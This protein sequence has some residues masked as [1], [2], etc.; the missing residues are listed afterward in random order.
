MNR[1][2]HSSGFTIIEVLCALALTSLLMAALY[3]AMSVYWTT[4]VE[5]YDEIERTQIA[6][7]LLRQM[8]RD[9][10]SCTFVEKETTELESSEDS[11]SDDLDPVDPESAMASYTDGLLGS[12]TDLVLYVSRPARNQTYV[13]AQELLDPTERSS[14]AMI[15]RYFLA[16]SSAGG[17]SGM[18][19]EQAAQELG[20]DDSVAGL[21][22]MTGDLLGLSNSISGGDVD[23]QL[24]ASD[25]LAREVG[26]IRFTYFDGVDEVEEWDS[27]QLGGMPLAVII[28]LTLRTVLPKTEERTSDQ[29]PG[30]L[31]DTVHRLVVPIPVA[32]PYVGLD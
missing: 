17:L 1:R 15:I 20:T 26:S 16:D 7:A 24:S 8:A 9:I 28:E 3:T 6:R 25:M 23:M 22:K 27:T 30:F 29:I 14:D 11:F 19:A 10:Q 12:D 21:A 32:E 5:S 18:M 2:V 4:A 31:E 13:S